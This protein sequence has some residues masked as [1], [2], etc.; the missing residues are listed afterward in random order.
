MKLKDVP[1]CFGIV[2]ERCGFK[3]SII[4]DKGGEGMI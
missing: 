3:E 1:G 2:I 4:A